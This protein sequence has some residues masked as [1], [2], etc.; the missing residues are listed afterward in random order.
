M[1]KMVPG[2]LGLM[3]VFFR[4]IYNYNVYIATKISPNEGNNVGTSGT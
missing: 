1:Y 3:P 4:Y 2:I